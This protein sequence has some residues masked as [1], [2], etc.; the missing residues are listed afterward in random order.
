MKKWCNV[1]PLLARL[2]LL[3]KVVSQTQNPP[4]PALEPFVRRFFCLVRFSWTWVCFFLQLWLNPELSKTN[5]LVRF[6]WNKKLDVGVL[7]H[8][9]NLSCCSSFKTF[10]YLQKWPVLMHHYVKSSCQS[11]SLRKE[12]PS[13]LIMKWFRIQNY[14]QVGLGQYICQLS[15]AE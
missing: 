9:S 13:K 12:L 7:R 8:W 1:S 3:P 4:Q 11:W 5:C 14:C 2:F 6:S 15:V 10:I